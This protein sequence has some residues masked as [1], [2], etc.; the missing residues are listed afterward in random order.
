MKY[1]KQIENIIDTQVL[2]I[3]GGPAGSAAAIAAARG[4]AKALLIERAGIL[5]GMATSGLVGP[6]MTCYNSHGTKQII[7]GLFEEMVTRA[8]DLGGAIHPSKVDAY[9]PYTSFIGFAHKHVTPFNSDILQVVLDDMACSAGVEVLCYTQFIDCFMEDERIAGVVVANKSGLSAI[10]AQVVIDATGD[11]D[12]AVCAGV[13]TVFGDVEAGYV[14]PVTLFFEVDGID[15]DRLRTAAKRIE[16]KPQETRDGLFKFP[17]GALAEYVGRARE[18]GDW[19]LIKSDCNIYQTNKTGRYKVNT[20]R[21]VDVDATD[22]QRLTSAHIDAKK[23]ALEILYCM[24]KYI[25]GCENA[26]LVQLAGAMGVRETRHIDGKYTLAMED[27]VSGRRF[28]D[29]IALCGYVLDIHPNKKDCTDGGSMLVDDYYGI[30]YRTLL[31]NGCTNL[32]VTGRCISATSRAASTL[33]IM[34][35]C[36][37]LGEAA[38]TAGALA[39]KDDLLP[40]QV[41]ADKLR[42]ALIAQNAVVD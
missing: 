6:F 2:V 32:L 15:T 10:R 35:C 26:E 8:E 7:K 41:D 38:G 17:I 27:V 20:T 34:P 9:S 37:A 28:E 19:N 13:K 1:E 40:Q 14:Q 31:P 12:V 16:A 29:D 18:N 22:A 21:V 36:M 4:G 5:G 42:A 3:G 33:R 25:P 11:A 23:Q 24:K 30:P 39:V